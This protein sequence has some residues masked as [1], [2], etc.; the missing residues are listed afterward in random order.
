MIKI[1]DVFNEAYYSLSQHHKPDFECTANVALNL[2]FAINPN[3]E[4][5]IEGSNTALD[6]NDIVHISFGVIAVIGAALLITEILT[7]GD[8]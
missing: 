7:G 8:I 3:I 5:E 4:V 1:I 2:P 6:L